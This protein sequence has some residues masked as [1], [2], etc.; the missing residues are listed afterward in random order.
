[1]IF[2]W[3]KYG[4]LVPVIFL[5]GAIAGQM[6]LKMEG[7]DHGRWQSVNLF[8]PGILL[9]VIGAI[10]DLKQQRNEFCGFRMIIWGG[11]SLVLGGVVIYLG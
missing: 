10:L 5:G 7:R 3:K 2:T 1:M 8:V 4:I 9:I 6:L 11:V